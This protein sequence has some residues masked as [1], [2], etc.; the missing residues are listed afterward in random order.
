MAPSKN[1]FIIGPGFIG[2]GVLDLLVAEGYQVTGFVRRREHGEQIEASG[3]KYVKGDLGDKEIITRHATESDII[4]HTATA[5]H[6]RSVEAILDAIKDRAQRGLMTIYIHTSGTSVLA[7]GAKGM[8]KSDKVYHDNVRSE[9][10]SVPDT[11]PHRQIDLAIIRAQK[12]IREKAKIAIM[13]PPLIYGYNPKHKRLTIQIPTLTRF[14]IKNGF[15]G[16]VGNGLSVK[17]NIHVL[18]LARAYVVL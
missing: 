4:I 13:T 7:D 17:S 16:Y 18:D 12:A 8:H 14:A 10:D 5:D 3:A 15:A 2:W 11:A 6:L 1:V 9:V